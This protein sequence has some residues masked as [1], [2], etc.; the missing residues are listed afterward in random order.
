MTLSGGSLSSV[1]GT[2]RGI[3]GDLADCHG[4]Q[5]AVELTASGVGEAKTR[6]VTGGRCD[7]CDT[8]E[9]F[10][11]PPRGGS[12]D[13]QTDK[14]RQ[15]LSNPTQGAVEAAL[16]KSVRLAE[17]GVT[18]VELFPVMF[19]KGADDFEDFLQAVSNFKNELSR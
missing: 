16:R 4:V 18:M 11:Y 7:G 12:G 1:I 2:S 19:C 3:T 9:D 10:D 14:H 6:H 15:H 5:A 17:A 13:T 8:D